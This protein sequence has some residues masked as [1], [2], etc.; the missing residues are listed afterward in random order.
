LELAKATADS[1]DDF[2]IEPI[3]KLRGMDAF[4][5]DDLECHVASHPWLVSQGLRDVPV[6][7]VNVS[8]QWGH[9]LVY[10]EMPE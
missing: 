1:L 6:F 9:I 4:L 7:V 3:L 10:F 8:T 2:V 5:A